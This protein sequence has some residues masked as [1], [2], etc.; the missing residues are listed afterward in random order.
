M[1]LL[2]PGCEEE[3]LLIMYALFIKDEKMINAVK[4]WLV[5]IFATT[6][7]DNKH[8]SLLVDTVLGQYKS[9]CG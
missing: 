8:V 3:I 7:A 6:I 1:K 2:N 9:A 4:Q 5:A